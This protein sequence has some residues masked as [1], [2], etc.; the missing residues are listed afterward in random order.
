MALAYSGV[1]LNKVEVDLKN[2]PQDLLNASAKGTVP[3]L[4][5]KEG[6]VIDESID[7]MLWALSIFDPD[8]WLNVLFKE[9]GDKLICLNDR[10]FKP[11]LDKYKYSK[12]SGIDPCVY[13]DKAHNY[14][15]QLDMRLKNNRFL[16]TN[17]ICLADIALFPFIRQFYMVD[18]QWFEHSDYNHLQR[19]LLYFLHS[20]LFLTVM[21]KF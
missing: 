6:L 16:L 8:D 20:K 9:S 4:I 5:L 21:K 18:Q 17:N 10:E 14:L 3:V 7:I 15:N 11:L 13:R 12:S 1:E 19:W 2:K